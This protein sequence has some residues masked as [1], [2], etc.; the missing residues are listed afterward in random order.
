[1]SSKARRRHE[2]GMDR[3]ESI[4]ERTAKKIQRSKNQARS[5]DSRRKTWDEVNKVISASSI[6]QMSSKMP[7]DEEE[8]DEDD[9]MDEEIEAEES[10]IQE[11]LSSEPPPAPSNVPPE[12]EDEV[13]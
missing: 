6:E 10:T 4:L 13:L 5:I 11:T 8:P 7:G 3:A 12:D 1:M 2:K 9:G